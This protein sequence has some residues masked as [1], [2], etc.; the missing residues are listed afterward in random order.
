MLASSGTNISCDLASLN[1]WSIEAVTL[2]CLQAC[3]ELSEQMQ[4]QIYVMLHKAQGQIKTFH[5]A[6]E[7]KRGGLGRI[8]ECV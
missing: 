2:W 5:I 6:S 3:S 7:M 8:E 4:G 1:G